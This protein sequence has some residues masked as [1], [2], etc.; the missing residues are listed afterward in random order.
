MTF[1]EE[2][3]ET[4]LFE[5]EFLKNINSFHLKANKKTLSKKKKQ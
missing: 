3:S 1:T 2:S 5:P 4:T